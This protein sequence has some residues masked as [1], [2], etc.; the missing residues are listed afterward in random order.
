[1]AAGV[2]AECGSGTAEPVQNPV[3]KGNGKDS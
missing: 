2:P 1:M 3:E